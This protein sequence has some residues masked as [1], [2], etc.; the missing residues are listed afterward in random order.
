MRCSKK[1]GSGNVNGNSV[2]ERIGI[3][4]VQ[5]DDLEARE[6]IGLYVADSG[7]EADD[8]YIFGDNETVR[9]APPIGIAPKLIR[10]YVVAR[11]YR[12]KWGMYHA[13]PGA[14]LQQVDVLFE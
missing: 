11:D 2:I 10:M 6:D 12:P 7:D 1:F 3:I 14:A 5:H 4:E 8:M 13:T 9:I